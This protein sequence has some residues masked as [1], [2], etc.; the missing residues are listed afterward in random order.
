MIVCELISNI[1]SKLLANCAGKLSL[2]VNAKH[3][4]HIRANSREYERE[5][6]EEEGE[7]GRSG[8]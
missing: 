2:P 8:R 1:K 5:E 4:G 3:C 7:R 6:Q